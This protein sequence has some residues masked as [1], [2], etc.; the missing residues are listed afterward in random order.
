ME[1]ET[2]TDPQVI[3]E[4]GDAFIWVKL[5][6]DKDPD[7]QRYKTKFNVRGYPAIFL[8][9]PAEN[10]LDQ[11]AG[12][13]PP[14]RFLEVMTPMRDGDTFA[15]LEEQVRERTADLTVA[16][17]YYGTIL[18]SEDGVVWTRQTSGTVSHLGG[19]TFTGSKTVVVGDD[20]VILMST[21]GINWEIKNAGVAK[22][23]NGIAS[24]GPRV[25]AV[26]DDGTI[27]ISPYL[28]GIPNTASGADSGAVEF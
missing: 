11:V 23:F 6:G 2:F 20:G 1:A 10:E 19:I 17:G 28:P 27:A 21:D 3:Q 16:V 7:G 14:D 22:P 15:G 12:Y 26:G 5:D 8:L 4:L 24:S 9:D 25:V 18:T 13:L